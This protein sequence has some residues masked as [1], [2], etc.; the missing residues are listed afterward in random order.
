MSCLLRMPRQIPD[1]SMEDR[2][3]E[4]RG[5]RAEIPEKLPVCAGD[6]SENGKQRILAEE[7]LRIGGSG[8][9][10]KPSAWI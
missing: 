2:A 5:M 4:I 9:H 8:R 10:I 1:A 3:K 6:R 7:I